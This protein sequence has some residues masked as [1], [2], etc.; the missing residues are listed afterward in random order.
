MYINRLNLGHLFLFLLLLTINLKA[1]TPVRLQ[2]EHLVNPLGIDVP[3]P[4]L[5]WQ[6]DDPRMGSKQTAFQLVVGTDS[7]SVS[8][9]VGNIWNTK[10]VQSDSTLITYAGQK[11]QPFTR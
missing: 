5:S 2:C 9:G 7:A 6:S 3:D 8:N 10:E 11:L 1:Q 4:R